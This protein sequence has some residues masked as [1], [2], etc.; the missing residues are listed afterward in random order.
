MPRAIIN[1]TYSKYLH[2]D[3]QKIEKNVK[4]YLKESYNQA[5]WLIKSLE[6]R[7]DTILRVATEILRQQDGFFAY[8]F[9]HLRP[10]NLK[11]VAEELELHESTVSRVTAGKYLWCPRGIFEMKFF[12]MSGITGSDG[13]ASVASQSVKHEIKKMI[14]AENPKAIL[15]DDD[16]VVK[17]Q[18]KDISI[19]RRT[20]AKYR[21]SMS[22]PSSIK[23]RCQKNSFF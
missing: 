15:S 14:D 16:I 23:R 4:R 9:E 5:S 8:G 13:E 6:Q 18:A 21:E 3:N 2:K 20:V 22:I 10:M 19:A 17:L 7:S 1:Q 12:F 11:T